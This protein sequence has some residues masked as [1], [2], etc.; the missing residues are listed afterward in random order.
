MGEGRERERRGR[1]AA[2]PEMAGGFCPRQQRVSGKMTTGTRGRDVGPPNRLAR[3]VSETP[4]SSSPF[5]SFT[6][7]FFPFLFFLSSQERN[8]PWT[9]RN[10][11]GSTWDL[12]CFLALV[13]WCERATM[14]QPYMETL[15]SISQRKVPTLLQPLSSPPS[16]RLSPPP[17]IDPHVATIAPLHLRVV[18]L[19]TW[20]CVTAC[21]S[22]FE[23]W[24]SR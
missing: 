6:L 18:V 21:Y 9:S 8:V 20:A 16:L 1:E 17:A 11:N 23:S 2:G 10:K 5:C 24:R 3:R 14:Y 7:L 22:S 12:F 13:R 4:L 15:I 19:E